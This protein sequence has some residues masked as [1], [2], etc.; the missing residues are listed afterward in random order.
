MEQDTRVGTKRIPLDMQHFVARIEV[1]STEQAQQPAV[2]KRRPALR[3]SGSEDSLSLQEQAELQRLGH[4]EL[5][6]Q[7]APDGNGMEHIKLS[8]GVD[9]TNSLG[10][11]LSPVIGNVPVADQDETGASLSGIQYSEN[12]P[13]NTATQP[14]LLS[15]PPAPQKRGAT[16]QKH[17]G[18]HIDVAESAL[19][20]KQGSHN[21]SNIQLQHTNALLGTDSLHIINRGSTTG[22]PEVE[23]LDGEQEERIA[24]LQRDY[25]ERRSKL[26]SKLEAEE[27]ELK[28]ALA[29]QLVLLLGCMLLVGFFS[30]VPDSVLGASAAQDL[31]ELPGAVRSNVGAVAAFINAIG[32]L[33]ALCQVSPSPLARSVLRSCLRCPSVTHVSFGKR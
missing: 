29:W 17:S 24:A 30:A 27:E 9:E 13:S 7:S 3:D 32:A 21:A 6:S 18:G 14:A 31:L 23:Q 16:E 11:S 12:E 22:Y 19:A 1:A 8:G 15:K 25:E 33:G 26:K 28:Q 20:S 10:R 4:Q 5:L 2:H